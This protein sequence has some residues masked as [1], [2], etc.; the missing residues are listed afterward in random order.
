MRID[1]GF[2]IVS[3]DLAQQFLRE[4]YTSLMCHPFGTQAIVMWI[5]S[6]PGVTYFGDSRVHHAVVS[7]NHILQNEN[8]CENF[9]ALH[10]AYPLG[11][12]QFWKHYQNSKKTASYLIPPVTYPCGNMSRTSYDYRK[13]NGIYRA[14]PKPCR[15][16]PVWTIA[17]FYPGRSGKNGL[18]AT[19]KD[20]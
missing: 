20:V 3:N 6:I 4:Q 17:D 14:K 18:V 11:M 10:G 16:K 5:N 15:E 9:L 2:V 19:N 7:V 12:T 13:F 8:I 1:E